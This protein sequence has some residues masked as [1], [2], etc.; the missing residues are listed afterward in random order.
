MPFSVPLVSKSQPCS[1]CRGARVDGQQFM[2]GYSKNA[3]C[4]SSGY[5]VSEPRCSAF[6][7]KIVLVQKNQNGISLPCSEVLDQRYRQERALHATFV[8]DIA[9]H[10]AQL[11]A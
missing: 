6:R 7:S 1:F 2:D 4:G 9:L 10:G 11:C 5:V 8:A 3:T